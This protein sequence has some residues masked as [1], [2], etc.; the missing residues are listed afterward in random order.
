[1][2]LVFVIGLLLFGG[3]GLPD[4]ARTVGKALREFKKA[5]ANVEEQFKQ[6][7]EDTPP[8]PP[9]RPTPRFPATPP[10]PPPA[11]AVSPPSPFAPEPPANQPPA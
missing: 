1:M 5:T 10:V 2:M 11:P 4:I 8:P 6:A 3:K 7:M 9:P